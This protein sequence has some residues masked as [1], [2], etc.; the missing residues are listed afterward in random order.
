MS[1]VFISYKRRLR[2]RVEEI[3]AALRALGLDVWF[4][5]E[6]EAGS[7]FSA[8]ISNE[9]RSAK[10]V[11]VCWS[12]DCFAHGGDKH[13]WVI[14]EASIGK[15]RERLVPVLLERAD[16]DPPWNTIHTESLIGWT[17][18]AADQATWQRVLVAIGHHVGRPDLAGESAAM[19]A[20]KGPR[21]PSYSSIAV[22]GLGSAVVTAI[23]AA[24]LAGIDP[25]LV[26][27]YYALV[28][29]VALFALPLA[30]LFWRAGVLPWWKGGLLIA[31][32]VAA[33]GLGAFLGIASIA[34][35]RADP[36][37]I[38]LEEII[39]CAVAGLVGAAV[40][41]AAF[42]LLGL[43]PRNAATATRIGAAA[44]LL[45][46]VAAFIAA[47]PFFN[48]AVSNS[49]I[50]WLGALWQLAYAPLLVFVL[51]PPRAGRRR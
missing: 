33:F 4:D 10:C 30:I 9:V 28:P 24:L 43:G 44:L 34:P 26:A 48:L 5:A 38:D 41:L 19:P 16:L 47:M 35:L 17:P 15:T 8:E 7:S 46:I 50:L 22:T 6:L 45:A 51:R 13:G 3:A 18:D 23:G 25:N 42:P 32:F 40:S 36:T 49:A 20:P 39:V 14:G 29:G 12:D 27:G 2:H 37:K 21:M 11:L 1:D 31:A